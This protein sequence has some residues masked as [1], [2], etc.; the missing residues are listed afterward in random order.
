MT[1]KEEEIMQI[2]WKLDRAFIKDILDEM[3][4]PKPH[5]NTVS[6]MMKI[7]EEKK[8]VS[9]KKYGNMLQ[10]EPAVKKEDYKTD[11]VGDIL[12]KYFDNSYI[13]MIA[14]FAKNE[15]MSE[16]EITD[17]INLIKTKK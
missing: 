2:L 10:Y 12:E 4:S 9:A 3:P 7:L 16:Q 5:Y 13:N 14:H 6:T 17:I 15:N 1:T 11:A 8:F